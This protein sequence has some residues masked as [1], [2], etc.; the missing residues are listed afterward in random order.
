MLAIL[1]VLVCNVTAKSACLQGLKLTLA[2]GKL[3]S[4]QA[5]SFLD[6]LA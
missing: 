5:S 6:L 3:K 1:L 4:S 2:Q